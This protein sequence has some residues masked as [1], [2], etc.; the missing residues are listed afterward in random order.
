MAEQPKQT[1]IQVAKDWGKDLGIALAIAFLLKAGVADARKVPTPSMVP[2]IQ[3]GD[4]IFVERALLQFTGPRRGDIIVFTPPV[5]SPDDY[6]KRVIGLPGDTIEVKKGQVYVNGVAQKEPYLAEAPHYT[7]G[8]VT[9]PE[10]KVFVLGDNRNQSYD[11]HS[12]G[13]LDESAIHGRA[14]VRYWP[15]DRAGRLD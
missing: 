2:T 15:L 11:S 6:L 8:P 5:P 7:Y 9:V 3:V 1:W 10:G 14:W 4:R 13:L 12:W